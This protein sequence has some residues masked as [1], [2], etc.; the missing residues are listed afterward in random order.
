MISDANR[1]CANSV[2]TLAS[3]MLARERGITTEE[4]LLSIAGTRAYDA[5]YDESTGLWGEGPVYFLNFF[6]ECEHIAF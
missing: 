1:W 6:Q 2:L 3:E 5:L 4:A